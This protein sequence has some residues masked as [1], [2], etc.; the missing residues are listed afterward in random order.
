MRRVIAYG[1]MAAAHG[2]AACAQTVTFF[3]DGELALVATSNSGV[4]EPAVSM[5]WLG[6][7]VD[8]PS[9]PGI[10]F[11]KL[12]NFY[13]RV[14]GT[15]SYPLTFAD[16]IANGYVRPLVQ[17]ADGGTGAIGTSVVSGPGYRRMNAPLQILPRVARVDTEVGSG[18]ERVSVRVESTYAGGATG[19][20][21][22][23]YAEPAVG[24]S[25]MRIQYSWTVVQ[26]M[27]MA[28]PA[29][30]RGNDCFRLCMFSSMLADVAGG[31]YDAN[32]LRIEDPQGRAKT[33][34]LDEDARNSHLFSSP[35]PT[36]V[37][38]SFALL[39]DTAA[40]WNAGSPS[41]EIHIEDVTGAPGLLG[42]QGWRLDSTDPND[43]SLS[44]WLEWMDAPAVL[45]TGTTISVALRVI[46]TPPTDPGDL[47]HDEDIDCDDLAIFDALMGLDE[48]APAFDAYAD[49][50]ADGVIDATDR[51]LLLQS[52]EGP[53]ADWNVSGVVN[54]QDFFDFLADF[55]GASADF[56]EDGETSSQD[57][58]DF[59]A[60]F[61][62]GCR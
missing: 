20:C 48:D 58:F 32:Y 1:I 14:P 5:Y 24:R 47:D 6:A 28:S 19:V 41:I 22:R 34:R 26:D 23:T 51:A 40:T 60:A 16:I 39:K 33:I 42:V 7:R 12:I 21:R 62:S 31:V 43:D 37:G 17:R 36:A 11:F 44:V 56:N 8:D 55:F 9:T 53:T 50:N 18:A 29:Q 45:K 38:R 3:D 57:F 52:L 27:T 4:Q 59:L 2:A 46:A 35:R 61:F 30:G 15:S 10:D 49:L 25:E 13:D 54:S